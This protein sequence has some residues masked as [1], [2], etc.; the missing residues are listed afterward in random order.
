MIYL[1]GFLLLAQ[2][3]LV[4]AEDSIHKNLRG[5]HFLHMQIDESL[6]QE[7][8]AME[9]LDLADIMELQL[10]RGAVDIRPFRADQPEICVPVAVL[11]IDTSDRLKTGVFELV[12]QVRDR[13]I[14]KRNQSEVV[15][16]T[17]E[18]RRSGRADSNEVESIKAVLRELMA[19]FVDIYREE[20]PLPFKPGEKE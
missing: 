6:N 12:L 14:I 1:L 16:T 10:R 9:R 15:A 18:L 17:F 3:Q 7:V 5:L 11:S 20:N 13:V 8:T 4:F 19:D 2:A